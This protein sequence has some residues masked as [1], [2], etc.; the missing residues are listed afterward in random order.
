[1]PHGF[2][3]PLNCHIQTSVLQYSMM[4]SWHALNCWKQPG[5]RHST[6][7]SDRISECQGKRCSG[8]PIRRPVW[9]LQHCDL[10]VILSFCKP[11][12]STCLIWLRGL[13]TCIQFVVLVLTEA[14]CHN[15]L[16]RDTCKN[17]S[18]LTVSLLHTCWVALLLSCGQV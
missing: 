12:T 9:G 2:S 14:A 8:C 17:P 10:P 7:Q 6:A 11:L 5:W 15:K 1:M 16:A 18:L 4:Q 13:A 3:S